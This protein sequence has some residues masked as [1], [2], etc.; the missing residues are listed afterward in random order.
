VLIALLTN[1]TKGGPERQG[2][3]EVSKLPDFRNQRRMSLQL[4]NAPPIALIKS[5]P[6]NRGLKNRNLPTSLVFRIRSYVNMFGSYNFHF[7]ERCYD[8]LMNTSVKDAIRYRPG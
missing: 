3:N 7:K 4:R 8:P 6:L 5:G 2:W 1:R